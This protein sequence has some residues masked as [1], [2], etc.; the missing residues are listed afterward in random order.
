MDYTVQDK[1]FLD[2]ILSNTP[3]VITRGVFFN[4]DGQSF[5]HVLFH[6]HATALFIF[7]TLLFALVDF[8]TGE[9]IAAAVVVYSA[10]LAL[11]VLRNSGGKSNLARKTLVDKRFL[12]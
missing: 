7:E 1:L 3:P 11:K 9:W 5:T 6:G 10:Y 4:D 8:F 12:I 2:S